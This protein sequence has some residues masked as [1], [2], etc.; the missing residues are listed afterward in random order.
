VRPKPT[1]SN[2]DL[3][4][5]LEEVDSR[6]SHMSLSY[7]GYDNQDMDDTDEEWDSSPRKLWRFVAWVLLIVFSVFA[8]MPFL[9]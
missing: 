9:L 8:L 6:D 2:H 1:T 7:G 3:D 4:E 5:E